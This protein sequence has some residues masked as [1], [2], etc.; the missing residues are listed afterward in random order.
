MASK[1]ISDFESDGISAPDAEIPI[2]FE[3]Y[4]N[5]KQDRVELWV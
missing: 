5:G 4:L 1:A 3:D 2:R